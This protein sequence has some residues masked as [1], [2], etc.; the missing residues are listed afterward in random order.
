MTLRKLRRRMIF[1][2]STP[3]YTVEKYDG[4]SST[5]RQ[6]LP[7]ATSIKLAIFGCQRK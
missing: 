5:R 1:Q 6:T 4:S 7:D 3:R 2:K